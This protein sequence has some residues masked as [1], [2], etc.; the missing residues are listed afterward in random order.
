MFFY[1]SRILIVLLVIM[2]VWRFASQYRS[3]PCPSWLGWM[4]EQE[5]P[6]TKANRAKTIIEN[7]NISKGMS[8]V[9]IGCGP[10]RVTIPLAQAVGRDGKVVAMDIQEKMLNK[11]KEKAKK[12]NQ[13]TITF[14]CAGIGEGKLPKDSFDRVVLVSVLGE[15]PDQLSA[16]K[17]IYNT[18]K[19]DGIL[20]ITEVIFDP[21]FQT[22]SSVKK[23]AAKIGFKEV[24]TFG[25]RFAYTMHLKK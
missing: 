24:R 10:G 9:D 4:V 5:N 15:V 11:V 21:H 12:Q 25:N 3:L 14:L 18:L 6:F 2:L 22:Q 16:F 7:L 1:L 19:P 13:H 20:S 23:L 8:V 17:E